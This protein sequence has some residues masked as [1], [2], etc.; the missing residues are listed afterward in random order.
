VTTSRVGERFQKN[1]VHDRED[2]GG[3]A[4]AKRERSDR[5]QGETG[6]SE[7]GPDGVPD[8]VHEHLPWELGGASRP[9]VSRIPP[10]RHSS[11]TI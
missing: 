3:R 5:H 11:A 2:R 1:R 6:G 9:L 8:V 10:Q 7:E 4:N